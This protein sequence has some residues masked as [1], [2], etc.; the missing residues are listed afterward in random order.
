MKGFDV[1]EFRAQSPGNFKA[2]F[3]DLVANAE[4]W[5]RR[6]A[7][8]DA[9][10]YVHRGGEG[11]ASAL[12]DYV[13]HLGYDLAY[14]RGAG[15]AFYDGT[16]W[17]FDAEG[18]LYHLAGRLARDFEGIVKAERSKAISEAHASLKADAT[19]ADVQAA[20][21]KA[22]ALV[23]PKA[24][25][26]SDLR[27]AGRVQAAFKYLESHPSVAADMD[28]F[29]ADPDVLAV[30]NGVVELR[31]GKLRAMRPADRITARLDVAYRED[32]TAPRFEQFLNEILVRPGGEP[33]PEL[34]AYFKRLIGYAI[35]GRSSEQAFWLLHSAQGSNGKSQLMVILQHVFGPVTKGVSFSTFEAGNSNENAALSDLA[36]LRNARLVVA[37][38]GSGKALNEG[39]I[40]QVTGEDAISAKYMRRDIFTYHAKFAMLLATNKMPKFS[41]DNALW[42]RVKIVPFHRYLEKH[43]RVQFLGLSIAETEA[44]GILAMAVA[45]AVKWYAQGLPP[46]AAIDQRTSDEKRDSDPLEDFLHYNVEEAEDGAVLLNDLWLRFQQWM[47]AQGEDRRY[48]VDL[49]QSNRD[50]KKKLEAR[51]GYPSNRNAQGG[52]QDRFPVRWDGRRLVAPG[53]VN[54]RFNEERFTVLGPDGYV[55]VG[56]HELNLGTDPGVAKYGGKIPGLRPTE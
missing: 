36:S 8:F 28:S 4:R 56:A 7:G 39:R 53:L 29:D 6:G 1:R 3:S 20:T 46:C 49:P 45:E 21:K 40:K 25:F 31:S 34:V 17:G 52:R 55:D 18:V 44:E 30:A 23:M 50:L 32:A 5:Y 26:I 13:R 47:V 10:P 11:M 48:D 19:E 27:N 24:R 15:W 33:D 14:T 16:R 54:Q 2:R 51:W 9:T 41:D 38:E 42:R 35:T 22:V 37:S 12:R 43:E